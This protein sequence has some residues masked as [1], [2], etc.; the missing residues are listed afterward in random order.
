VLNADLFIIEKV[1]N[2]NKYTTMTKITT[3]SNIRII[4]RDSDFLDR[5]SGARGEVFYDQTANT[6]RLYNGI[7]TG[8]VNLAK[9]N[10]SNV[11]NADFLAKSIA[12]GT[13]GAGGN[14]ELTIAGDDST[15]RTVSSGNVLKFVGSGG[16]TTA[17]TAD[18]EI[19]INGSN[20]FSTI[21]VAGQSNVV[22]DSGS[23]SLTLVAGTNVTITTDASTDT[24]T[25]A[26]AAGASTNSFQ[27]IVVSGESSVVADS[28]TDSLTLVAGAGISITTNAGTDT[29]TITNSATTVNEFTDLGDAAGLTVD[30]FYLPAITMLTVSNSGAAA[31]R[32][33]QYG[34]SDNPTIYAV[35]GTTIAFNLTAT[36][37]PFLIQNAAGINYSTGLIHVTTAGVVTTGSSAQGKDSGTLYWKIPTDI[38]GG[39]RYQ[40]GVHAPMVG[41]I[42]VKAFSTL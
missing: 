37:H 35:N 25:I 28:A 24:I 11:S 9:A 10:L 42:T 36:G 14:F 34:S 3:Q 15:V 40:C 2:K 13:G 8:G 16:I 1:P 7:D 31:Y 29:I 12:A 23:D 33:D 27:T 39:Y 5:K 18:G 22:A 20:T 21:V 30:K 41:S 4:P 38:S 26:A 32:F 17:T 6:L 19:T